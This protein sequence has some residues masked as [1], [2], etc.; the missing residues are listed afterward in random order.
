[1][2]EYVI[3]STISLTV[4]YIL[5]YFLL[6]NIKSFEFNRFYLFFIVIFSLTIPFIQISTGINLTI[7]QNVHNYSSS[8]SNINIQGLMEN[9][10]IDNIFNISHLFLIVYLLISS[11]LLMRFVFNLRKII[12]IIKDSCK[13]ANSFPRIVLSPT[14]TLPYSFFNYIIINKTDYENGQI[15]NDLILHE[16]VHCNQYHSIDI[17]FIEI[18]KV[19]FWFNPIIWIIKKEIQLNHEYL[20][21]NDVLQTQNLKSYQEILLNLVFRNNSTYLASNFNYS[22]TKKRLIMM[23]KNNSSVNSMARKIAIVPLVLVLAIT[24]TFSQENEPKNS[25]MNFDN[26]WWVPI[27]KKH[28]KEVLAFNNFENIFEMGEKNSIND[29]I[30]TLE[31]AYIIIRDTL[32]NY[33]IIESPL[34]Y[35]DFN[36]EIIKTNSG[37][38][39]KFHKD[40]DPDKPIEKY[41][42]ESME[43]SAKRN[44]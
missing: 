1:M 29:G 10:Q 22:L 41:I 38:M 39:L 28:N 27:L 16:Q 32:D 26:E 13:T 15:A 19:F 4:L 30:C 44:R 18:I 34:V 24:L 20:A 3:K 21:D 31:N 42:I 43:L 40:S 17:I 2:A 33:M 6:R 23:T 5:Y 36:N 7:N 35:H 12:R 37:T 9:G 14:K 25:S 8:I 11:I